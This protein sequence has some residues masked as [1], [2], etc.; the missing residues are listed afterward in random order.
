M[1]IE[2]STLHQVHMIFTRVPLLLEEEQGCVQREVENCTDDVVIAFDR[3]LYI[4]HNITSICLP[5]YFGNLQ[6][7]VSDE[8]F[9]IEQM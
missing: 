6:A 9:S 3:K 1:H 8:L 4:S 5:F 2:L 7:F